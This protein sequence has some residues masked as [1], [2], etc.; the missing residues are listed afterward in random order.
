MGKTITIKQLKQFRKTFSSDSA[1]KMAQ[2]AIS[3]NDLLD[4]ALDRDLV[5]DIDFSFSIKLDD[6]KVTNQMSSGRCWLHRGSVRRRPERVQGLPDN[7]EERGAVQGRTELP[8]Q[9]ARMGGSKP[10]FL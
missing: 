4:V 7:S 5:Q 9:T 2:N 10:G 6:W 3:N 8:T 1:A